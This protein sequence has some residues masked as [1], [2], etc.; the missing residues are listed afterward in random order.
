[1]V[2][3]AFA[4][5]RGHVAEKYV[6]FPLTPALS[7]G[8]RENRFPVLRPS[9]TP[10]GSESGIRCLPLPWGEGRGEGEGSG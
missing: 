3:Q 5:N 10:L 4:T 1:M 9:A 6:G 2:S 7:L 8:E